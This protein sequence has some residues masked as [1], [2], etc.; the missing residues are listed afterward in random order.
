M[1][2]LL[3][4]ALAKKNLTEF[5]DPLSRIQRQLKKLTKLISD[6]LDV[7]RLQVAKLSYSFSKFDMNELLKEVTETIKQFDQDRA[8]ILR[9]EVKSEV[10]GDRD[11][12]EQVLMNLLT[13]ATK[14]SPKNSDIEII[15]E[16]GNDRVT[17]CIIDKGMG[18]DMKHHDKIFDRFYRVNGETEST[19]PGMGI[20]LYISSEILKRHSGKIW[21][22]SEKGRGSKFYFSLPLALQ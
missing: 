7:S 4:I 16:S 15:V 8:I 9:G 1:T 17:V 14:Y 22:E 12:I 6:L 10:Y 11:R 21:V 3:D 20:G 2:E 19:Y 13:N 18:I 5:T